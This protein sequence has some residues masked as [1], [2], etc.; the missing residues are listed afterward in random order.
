MQAAFVKA[1]LLLQLVIIA[2]VAPSAALNFYSPAYY[3]DSS[4]LVLCCR[5]GRTDRELRLYVDGGWFEC[6]Q[7]LC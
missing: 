4:P 6:C 1:M 5:S 2:M 7:I 3:V